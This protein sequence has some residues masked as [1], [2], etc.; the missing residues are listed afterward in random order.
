MRQVRGDESDRWRDL[1][2]RALAD[3]PEAFSTRVEEARAWDD[4]EWQ[5]R[6]DAFAG[7]DDRTMFVAEVGDRWIGC[8]GVF[9]HDGAPPEVISVWV[10]P[11][12]RG[13]GVGEAVVGAAVEWA[14]GRGAPRVVL[15]VMPDNG[16]AVAMYERLGFR[17]TGRRDPGRDPAVLQD[18]MALELVP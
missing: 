2:I 11:D 10:S 18:E 9:V 12:H 14:R 5:R 13:R 1:R 3:A 7:G 16:H 4:L 6:T 8:A 15:H 17:R